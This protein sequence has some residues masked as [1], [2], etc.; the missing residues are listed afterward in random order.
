ME[1][2]LITFKAKERKIT[3]Q[4][5]RRETIKTIMSFKDILPRCVND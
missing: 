1:L 4:I 5:N 2:F 3:N